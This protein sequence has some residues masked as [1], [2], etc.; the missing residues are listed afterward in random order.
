MRHILLSY[1]IEEDSPVHIGLKDPRIS[2]S[3]QISEGGG[4][5]SYIINVENHSG[6]HV[7]APGHFIEG[8]KII[9]E[10]SSDE[11]IFKDPLLLDTPKGE[12]KLIKL[13]EISKLDLKGKDCLIFRTGFG[14]Y[15][16]DE[17]Y[18]NSNPGIHP[19]LVYWL[20]KKYPQIR[21]IGID[22]ISISPFQKPEEGK[23]AHLNAFIEN[24]ELG[25]PLILLEDMKLDN[26]K[27]VDS[28]QKI[29]VVPWQ[30]KG[31]D[32]SPCTVIAKIK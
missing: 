3:S 21:C 6:T 7:D 24:K 5:N 20:R 32:S 25:D 8:A 16:N 31:I 28:I 1:M 2:P 19:D 14:R 22:C 26:I 30:I 11:L 23:K 4:Y 12:N 29:Y 17:I 10:Y 15:R 9:S 18:L 27:N 13:E